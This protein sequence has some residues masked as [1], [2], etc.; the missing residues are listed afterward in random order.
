[1]SE[2]ILEAFHLLADNEIK[3]TPAL[4]PWMNLLQTGLEDAQPQETGEQYSLPVVEKHFTKTLSKGS[5]LLAD[6]V[7]LSADR[8]SWGIPYAEHV[9]EPDM[10][11]LRDNY[12]FAPIIGSQKGNRSEPLPAPLYS[13][14]QIYAGVVLQGPHI[15]YPPLGC[16]WGTA[17]TP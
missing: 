5:G 8:L 6:I 12:A 3:R 4:A 11:E 17:R 10:D 15:N 1:M 16:P 7:S 13:S 2:P 14:D 9:G